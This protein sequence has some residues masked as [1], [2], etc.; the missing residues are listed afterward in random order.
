[1]SNTK[2]NLVYKDKNYFFIPY[3]KYVITLGFIL[4]IGLAIIVWL[5]VGLSY[6]I[7]TVSFISVIGFLIWLSYPRKYQV[8]NDHISIK[9][10]LR[11]KNA[12]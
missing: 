1:M 6:G 7:F 9:Y 10:W 2:S 5:G 11:N 12:T 8:Y 3:R 4:L